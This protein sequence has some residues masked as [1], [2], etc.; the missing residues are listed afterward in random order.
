MRSIENPP[1]SNLYLNPGS[2]YRHSKIKAGS[3][4]LVAQGQ[5]LCD[6]K[7]DGLQPRKISSF[8]RPVKDDL[9]L[10][11]TGVYSINCECGQVYIGQTGRSIQT[12]IK[13]QH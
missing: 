11:T 6:I 1:H 3:F 8:H 9:G 12:R 10:G 7:C 4:N 5:A 2:H 13:E